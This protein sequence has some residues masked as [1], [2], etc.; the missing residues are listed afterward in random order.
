MFCGG[1]ADTFI[2]FFN[3]IKLF[4]GGLGK[5]PR[6]PIIGSHVPAYMEKAN[7]KFLRDY[8]GWDM[9]E[10]KNK[11]VWLTEDQIHSGDFVAIFRL[12]G[13]D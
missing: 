7:V 8:V 6:W 10:R 5:D 11:K 4:V 3:T 12:D 1:V 13:L 2:S 9:K